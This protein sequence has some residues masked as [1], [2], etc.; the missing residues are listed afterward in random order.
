MEKVGWWCYTLVG[1]NNKSG[2]VS[3]R[4]FLK[5]LFSISSVGEQV[6]PM[7]GPEGSEI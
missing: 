2:I 1:N 7:F 3:E 5:I 6:D 4:S